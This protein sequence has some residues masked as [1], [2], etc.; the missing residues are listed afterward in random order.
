LNWAAGIVLE[1]GELR[2]NSMGQQAVSIAMTAVLPVAAQQTSVA[3]DIYDMAVIYTER[4]EAMFV[5]LFKLS[6]AV[7]ETGAQ[8]QSCTL[9]LTSLDGRPSSQNKRLSI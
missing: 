3:T 4:V 9:D 2:V 1:G 8:R 7:T 5:P 6:A